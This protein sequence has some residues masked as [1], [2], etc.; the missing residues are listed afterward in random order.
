[1]KRARK[2]FF[3]KRDLLILLVLL[4]T[5]SAT[6]YSQAD[7]KLIREGNREYGKEKYSE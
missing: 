7:R 6:S 2:Y 5:I 1:M 4:I 3:Q